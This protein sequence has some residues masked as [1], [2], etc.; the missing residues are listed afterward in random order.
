MALHIDHLRLRLPGQVLVHDLSATVEPGQVLAVMGPSG[1][2][3]SSL[4]AWMAGTLEAPFE[5]QGRLTLNGRDLSALPIQARW[6]GLL[7]QDDLLFPHLSVQD[8]LLFA[9]PAGDRSS[10]IAQAQAALADAGLAGY[11]PRKPAS[12]SGGQR[13]RVALLRALLAR[14]AAMLLDEPFSKLDAALRAQMRT[15]TFSLLRERNVPT[16]LVTHD[17]ADVPEG[18][19]VVHL[20]FT[21]SPS[22]GEGRGG[23]EIA[24]H[25]MAGTPQH[26]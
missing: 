20:G 10:R 14:P 7:F 4:L 5:A 19:Q 16:V 9:L 2:G 12:L 22:T 13:S 24:T 23:G 25:S 26:A 21:P 8:N 6:V 17:E 15:F 18:A 1:S 3:K 11:G